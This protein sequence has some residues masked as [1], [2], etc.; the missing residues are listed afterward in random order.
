MC[1]LF[2]GQQLA[3]L[4]TKTQVGLFSMSTVSS[5]HQPVYVKIAV[6]FIKSIKIESKPNFDVDRLVLYYITIYYAQVI[7]GHLVSNFE[8]REL[9]L[10]IVSQIISVLFIRSK[11]SYSLNFWDARL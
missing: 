8:I 1:G 6:Y 3:I 7:C 10:P 2:F 9:D 4:V 5:I 11:F